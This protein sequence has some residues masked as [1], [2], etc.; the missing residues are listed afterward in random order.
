MKVRVETGKPLCCQD[1]TPRD[2]V[3][4]AKL[5]ETLRLFE[6]LFLDGIASEAAD[7]KLLPS[8]RLIRL[9]KGKY[10]HGVEDAASNSGSGQS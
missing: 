9:S 4:D 5:P 6:T 1:R 10:V 7:P 2:E 3:S 8:L